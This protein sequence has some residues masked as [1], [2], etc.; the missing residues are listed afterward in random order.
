MTVF[1][2]KELELTKMRDL[3][4]KDKRGPGQSRKAQRTRRKM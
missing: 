3:D 1:F 4:R 2:L